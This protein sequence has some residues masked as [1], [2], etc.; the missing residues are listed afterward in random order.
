[1]NELTLTQDFCRTLKTNFATVHQQIQI[2]RTI[3]EIMAFDTPHANNQSL[4]GD[5]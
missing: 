1:M 5:A 4:L 2:A 3:G